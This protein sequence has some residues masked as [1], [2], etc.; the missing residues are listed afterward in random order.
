MI[1]AGIVLAA[2]VARPAG[3]DTRRP[4]AAD[5]TGAMKNGW[6]GRADMAEA[7]ARRGP[8]TIPGAGYFAWG[9]TAGPR[10]IPPR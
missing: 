7:S 3:G 9:D 6:L 8:G 5:E 1:I 10:W 2:L 4:G